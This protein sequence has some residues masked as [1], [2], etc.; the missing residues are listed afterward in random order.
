MSLQQ[1]SLIGANTGCDV[2][3]MPAIWQAQCASFFVVYTFSGF[4]ESESSDIRGALGKNGA[5]WK[6]EQ[7]WQQCPVRG[8]L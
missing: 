1:V 2:I 3:K 8:D 4:E 5:S 6:C 7:V